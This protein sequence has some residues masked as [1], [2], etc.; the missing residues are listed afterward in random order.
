MNFKKIG[1]AAAS[2]ATVVAGSLAATAPAEAINL[3]FSG[4]GRFLSGPPRVDFFNGVTSGFPADGT[5]TVGANTN[6]FLADGGDTLTIKD[7]NLVS[8]GSNTW[9]LSGPVDSFLSGF[10]GGRVFNLTQFDLTRDGDDSFA[11][12]AGVLNPAAG[13]GLAGTLTTQR[14]FFQARGSTYS[15]QFVPTPALI[16]ALMGMGAAAFRKRK[17]EEEQAQEV[18]A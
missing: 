3:S 17:R 11:V 5:A 16:P 12:I 7:L 1:L 2:A 14:A 9:S 18:K 10:K 8:T 15:V 6:S 13:S 4:N